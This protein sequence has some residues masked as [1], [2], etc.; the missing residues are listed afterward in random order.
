M[1]RSPWWLGLAVV[2]VVVMTTGCDKGE[3]ESAAACVDDQEFFQ[4]EVWSKFM[5]DDCAGCHYNGGS[6]D[7]SDLVLQRGQGKFLETNFTM[8]KDVADFQK[9]GVSILLL[10]PTAQITHGGLERIKK[11]GPEY[12]ALQ[13]LIRR[14]DNPVTCGG[15]TAAQIEKE[16]VELL[17]PT[18]TFRKASLNLGG[19]LPTAAEDFRIATGGEEALDVELDRLIHEDAF[20]VRLEEMIN[21]LFLTDRYLDRMNALDLLDEDYF[22][23]A[24]WFVQDDD[25]PKDFSAE[26]QEFLEN[27]RMYTNDSV[28]RENLKLAT[29]IVRNDRPFTEIITANYMVMN[30]YSARA[31]GVTDI[32]FENPMDV[33]EWK[34]GHI[35]GVPHSGV[36][37]S[38]MWLNR[39][40]TTPTNRN[41]HRARM[42][43]SFFL[44]TDVMKLASRPLDPTSSIPNPTRENPDCAV[45]HTVIDPV[46][47]ALQN[48]NE[49][50]S[51]QPPE[52]GWYEEMLL[53]GF[54]DK[55]LPFETDLLTASQWLARQIAVDI[56]F[57]T[58]IIHH[59]FRGITGQEPLLFPN[60]SSSPTYADE[61]SEYEVQAQA[62]DEIAAKFVASDYN[63]RVIIKEIVKSQYYRA[64]DLKDESVAPIVN[65]L[66]TARLLTPELLDRKIEAV[67]GIPWS[68][69]NG[70]RYLLTE[71]EYRMLYGGI[72]SDDVI[73]RITEPN[74][75]MANIQMRMA[76]EMACQ[77]TARDFTE[78]QTRRRFFP[79]V[80]TSTL[81]INEAG[82]PE[83]EAEL[84]IRK[85]LAHMHYH[86]LGEVLE[87]NDPEIT[88]SFNLYVQTLQEGRLKM[89]AGDLTGDFACRATTNLQGVELPEDLQ[90][91]RDD[92]YNIRAWMAVVT[93]LL[94]DFKFLYE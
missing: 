19:R 86:V 31:Y 56:R 83:P 92:N 45:C 40:P 6:A 20:Y 50:G 28:A 16:A 17:T 39:F 14:F 1:T 63:L 80:E 15:D 60:D 44:A 41:R 53:P 62:F 81:P 42:V 38:P 76:N 22:P 82:F 25:N 33:N 7:T 77:V 29:Y 88:R 91:R 58:A 10:K 94:A 66:G 18:E 9:D 43:Y 13:E 51:Y 59:M 87:P 74:G 90:I 35:P 37:S 34:E 5:G 4:K 71:N 69:N 49:Q 48:W 52:E 85:N 3:E 67:T 57:P 64:K 61:V 30:P 12:K 75:I 2:S 11:D 70:D 21:D 46:A 54:E 26:N 73:A 72:D 93:Y 27:A 47:G 32:A 78:P 55:E 23:D 8:L 89:A 36:L 65:H 79:F 24:R 84:K 68:A